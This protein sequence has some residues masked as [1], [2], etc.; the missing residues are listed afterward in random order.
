MGQL[1]LFWAQRLVASSLELAFIAEANPVAQG[2]HRH[3]QYLGGH[4]RRLPA[5]DQAHRLQLEFQG[6]FAP[7]LSVFSLALFVISNV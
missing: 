3:A 5:F 6:V 7:G 4:R 2:L 1:H